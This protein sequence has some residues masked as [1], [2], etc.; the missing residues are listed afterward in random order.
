MRIGFRRPATFHTVPAIDQDVAG[1]NSA[2]A[3]V[4]DRTE[5]PRL[6]RG[7]AHFQVL[8]EVDAPRMDLAGPHQRAS[9]SG[10]EKLGPNGNSVKFLGECAGRK[11]C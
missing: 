11:I 3:G 5:A 4:D 9:K 2:I 6:R 10:L 7:A 1:P 8:R